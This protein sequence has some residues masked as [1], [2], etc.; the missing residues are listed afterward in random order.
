MQLNPWYLNFTTFDCLASSHSD[1]SLYFLLLSSGNQLLHPDAE[2]E[3]CLSASSALPISID[4]LGNS[5]L[6]SIVVKK[7][8]CACHE[9]MLMD[10]SFDG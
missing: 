10:S 1:Y 8:K 4:N 9:R 3:V 6:A 7:G 2:L 5:I